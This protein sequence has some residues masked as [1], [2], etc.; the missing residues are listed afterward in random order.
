MLQN[1][2]LDAKIGV[3]PAENEPRKECWCR[4]P[5]VTFWCGRDAAALLTRLRDGMPLVAPDSLLT[6]V[7]P[8]G[9]RLRRD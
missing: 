3:D 9:C 4:G 7:E 8:G 5:L 2:Y 6:G 1:A